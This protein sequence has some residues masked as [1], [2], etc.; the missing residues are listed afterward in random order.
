M[1]NVSD[2]LKMAFAMLIFTTALTITIM[3]FTKARQAS[4]G[5]MSQK[6]KSRTYYNLDGTNIMSEK[7]V[8]IDAVISNL[9]SY[10]QT[11]DTIVF[12]KGELD[13]D[14]NLKDNTIKKMPIYI[15][16]A[17]E[18][19]LNKSSLRIPDKQIFG[20]DINDESIRQ[21][22]WVNGE[23]RSKQFVDFLI[24]K[25]NIP[26]D[27]FNSSVRRGI[28]FVY[29][30][31]GKSILEAINAKF[32]ERIGEYNRDLETSDSTNETDDGTNIGQFN[33]LS[34]D[35]SITRFQETNET[36]DN[37]KGEKKKIIEYIYIDGT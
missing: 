13:S 17:P 18:N 1:E 26:D 4:T 7:E 22:Q 23:T 32:I 24:N 36:I 11:Q 30:L 5:I 33:G 16:K 34:V 35:S 19:T 25:K 9:Y 27:Y 20:L 29:S 3:V 8:G 15:T 21:E 31:N 37:S 2:A 12:F 10:Y 14:G 6:E 28:E